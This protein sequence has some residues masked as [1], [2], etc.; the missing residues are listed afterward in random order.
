MD[1]FESAASLVSGVASLQQTIQDASYAGINHVSGFM[2]GCV[3]TPKKATEVY[4]YFVVPASGCNHYVAGYLLSE[5]DRIIDRYC[6]GFSH[7]IFM[8]KDLGPY[9]LP[10]IASGHEHHDEYCSLDLGKLNQLRAKNGGYTYLACDPDVDY[11]KLRMETLGVGKVYT[12]EE[13][14]SIVNKYINASAHQRFSAE[15][16][17]YQTFVD[18]A[19]AH[20]LNK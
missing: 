2:K 13:F 17:L 12:R 7:V 11:L 8:P 18:L 16:I 20:V 9:G 10:L 5:H 4:V 3:K 1:K 6:G 14:C 15:T 19:V